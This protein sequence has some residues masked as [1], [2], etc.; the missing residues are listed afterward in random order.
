MSLQNWEIG[1]IGNEQKFIDNIGIFSKQYFNQE[2][3]VV[4]ENQTSSPLTYIVQKSSPSIIYVDFTTLSNT[5][6]MLKEVLFIR[7]FKQYKCILLCAI[8]SDAYQINEQLLLFASGFQFAYIKGSELNSFLS[9]SFY[10]A[11]GASTSQKK[12]SIA[13]GLEINLEVGICSTLIKMDE[14]YFTIETD[15]STDQDFLK[16]NFNLIEGLTCQKFEVLDHYST[17]IFSPMTDTYLINFPYAGPWDE[18]TTD[19]VQEET[20]E[21]W[22]DL[23]KSKMEYAHSFLVFT[24]SESIFSDIYNLSNSISM[25]NFNISED[26]EENIIKEQ[27]RTNEF[28]MV[29]FDINDNVHTLQDLS[30]LIH[31]INQTENYA[32]IVIVFG[33]PSKTEAL[34]KLYKYQQ[35]LSVNEKLSP[36]LLAPFIAT[37]VNKAKMN[38]ELIFSCNDR[39]RGICVLLNI[40]ILT[41]TEQEISFNSQHELAYFSIIHLPLPIDCFVTIIP[42]NTPP[43]PNA[44]KDGFL[45]TGI[46]HSMTEEN[47]NK[48]RN[49]VNQIIH[50]P[51][52]EL[53]PEI[54]KEKLAQAPK[55]LTIENGKTK[56][57][58]FFSSQQENNNKSSKQLPANEKLSLKGKS[59]LRGI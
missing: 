38:N 35:I 58:E 59:K 48:L 27:I 16:L 55:F 31:I 40:V 53:S 26:F 2:V 8:L 44:K 37:Y 23:H 33:T 12:F 4:N 17:T 41:L 46:I 32:P 30:T 57:E 22:I 6:D 24:S 49:F 34:Q 7:K 43:P 10:I 19:T 21:T 47:R 45:Y 3:K 5:E 51:I 20:V 36:T 50:E 11:F 56:Q 28:N 9:Q 14:F 13:K 18:V 52:S 42:K 25:I 15:I 29:L 54:A 1:Y 39:N